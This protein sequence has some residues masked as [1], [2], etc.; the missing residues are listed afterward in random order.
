MSAINAPVSQPNGVPLSDPDGAARRHAMRVLA[1]GGLGAFV[2]FL[3]VTI[4]SIG[5]PTIS[6]NFHTTNGHLAWVLNAYNL[7]AAAMLIPAGRLADRYGRKRVFIIGLIGFALTSALC[8]A[9]PEAG[10]LIAGR[11]LQA[12]FAALM[13]PTSLALILPEFPPERRHMALGVWGSM[14]AVAA[15]VAPTLGG[16]LTEYSTWRLIFLINVPICAILVIFGLRLLRESRDPHAT[17]IPDPAGAVLVAAIPALI[18]FAIIEGP[19]WGWSDPRLIAAFA[20]AVVLL[21]VFLWRSATATR[22]V[23]DL[24]L[25]KV[26]QFRQLNITSVLFATA[27]Y[28]VLFGNIIFLQTEWHYSILR[29]ALANLPGPLVVIVL[30]RPIS[31]V[32]ARVGYRP[33]LIAGGVCWGLGSGAFALQTTSSPEFVAHWLPGV[34]LIGLGAALTLLVLPGAATQSLPP[35]RYALGSAVNSS[36]QQLG[37]VLG[38]SLFVAVLGT[39][40]PATAMAHYHRIW[41]L[42][43]AL[44][45]ASGLLLIIPRI[46]RAQAS[47]DQ[48]DPSSPYRRE[49]PAPTSGRSG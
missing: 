29:A 34:L 18:S 1:L 26:R 44:G 22:P 12:A 48:P 32:V 5:I 25:F 45:L 6:R 20:V 10:T 37:A 24:A 17:G 16:L 19:A 28:G 8:G 2:V 23:V 14:G 43:A 40:T 47:P 31:T 41:W 39:V 13:L 49:G 9:A 38:V 4:V 15:A 36:A 30:A 42:F 35:E 21:P 3:D 46:A 27:F 11:A 7:V 33:L